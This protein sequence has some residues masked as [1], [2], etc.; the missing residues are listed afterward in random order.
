MIRLS[1]Q[2]MTP[3]PR[4]TK[5]AIFALPLPI[6][7]VGTAQVSSNFSVDLLRAAL[8]AVVEVHAV[9]ILGVLLPEVLDGLKAGYSRRVRGYSLS[10]KGTYIRCAPFNEV[11]GVYTREER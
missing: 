7:V 2:W 3:P 11:S 4:L 5:L 10:L 1:V 9:E 8:V 6:P